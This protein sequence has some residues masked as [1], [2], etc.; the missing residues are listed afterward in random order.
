MTTTFP[1]KRTPLRA[2]VLRKTAGSRQEQTGSRQQ[3]AK[4]GVA[5]RAGAAAVEHHEHHEGK[6]GEGLQDPLLSVAFLNKGPASFTVQHL[7]E[8]DKFVARPSGEVM[9]A[10]DITHIRR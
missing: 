4:M 3:T 6:G 1:A 5:R 2:R 8:L 9:A 10:A 7:S